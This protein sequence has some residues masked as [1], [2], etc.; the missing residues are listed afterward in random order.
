MLVR[1]LQPTSANTSEKPMPLSLLPRLV[2]PCWLLL[3]GPLLATAQP[4]TDGR[5]ATDSA[6]TTAQP[7]RHAQFNVYPLDYRSTFV[8]QSPVLAL[9]GAAGFKFKGRHLFTIGYYWLSQRSNQRITDRANTVQTLTDGVKLSY[10]NFAYTWSFIHCKHWEVGLPVEVGYGFSREAI[11]NEA[12]RE[13]STYVSHFVPLQIGITADWKITRWAGLNL[14]VGYRV[15][16][17][18]TSS[19]ADFDGVYYNYGINLYTGNMLDDYRAWRK[20]RT[21]VLTSSRPQS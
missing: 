20:R 12:G 15:I 11:N 4:V 1:L 7:S 9:G 13:L 19:R 16:P 3:A 8:R 10:L 17:V 6:Q 21:S 14:A 2:Q 18:K 5:I